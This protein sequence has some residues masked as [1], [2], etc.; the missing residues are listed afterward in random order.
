MRVAHLGSLGR[1]ATRGSLDISELLR[2]L[3]RVGGRRQ[4]L[5]CARPKPRA[6]GANARHGK[7][8]R[9]WLARD[10]ACQCMLDVPSGVNAAR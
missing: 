3:R 5:R 4:Q 2:V 8:Q 7:G 1:A 10:V 6:C 9:C